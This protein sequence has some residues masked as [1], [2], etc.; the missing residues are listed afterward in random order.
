MHL[1]NPQSPGS[2]RLD[3][4]C[5]TGP[6]GWSL[7]PTDEACVLALDEVDDISVLFDGRTSSSL[8]RLTYTDLHPL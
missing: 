8:L 4:A 3:G 2:T 7:V 1:V 6:T 5:P